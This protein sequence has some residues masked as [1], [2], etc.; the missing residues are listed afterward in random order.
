MRAS[1]VWVL[2]HDAPWL[3]AGV[4]NVAAGSVGLYPEH[5]AGD[6]R[7][8]RDLNPNRAAS[9]VWTHTSPTDL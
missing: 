7:V 5:L 3:E 2:S 1:P 9:K 4:R 6:A 8:V